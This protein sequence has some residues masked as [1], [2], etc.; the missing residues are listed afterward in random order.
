MGKKEDALREMLHKYRKQ[1]Q[2]L[3]AIVEESKRKDREREDAQAKAEARERQAA[4]AH[5]DGTV[6]PVR[7]GK[8]KARSAIFYPSVAPG[9]VATTNIPTMTRVRVSFPKD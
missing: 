8:S 1:A 2:E 3:L 6:V 9:D 7:Q 5:K 4:R